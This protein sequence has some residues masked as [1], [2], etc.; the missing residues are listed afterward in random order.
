MPKLTDVSKDRVFEACRA[1][2]DAGARVT[3]A[4]VYEQLGRRGSA[5]VVQ[6]FIAIWQTTEDQDF[7]P[8]LPPAFVGVLRELGTEAFS[9]AMREAES[10]LEQRRTELEDQ[11]NAER[12]ATQTT[13]R[14][15]QDAMKEMEAVKCLAE[16]QIVVMRQELAVAAERISA[17]SQ[18]VSD[19]DQ[20]V[21]AVRT[22]L[23]GKTAELTTLAS[24]W[25]AAVAALQ[26]E[27]RQE[28]LAGQQALNQERERAAGERQHLM[29][30]T[31]QIRQDKER[32]IAELKGQLQMTDK[33]LD[34][35]RGHQAVAART[36]GELRTALALAIS[37]RDEVQ[38]R[39]LS[40]KQQ[41]DALSQE[42]AADRARLT[43][44]EDQI[45]DLAKRAVPAAAEKTPSARRRG[46]K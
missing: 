40:L 1:V 5:K 13:V 31:D 46:P 39:E 7:L 17:L 18:A 42:R 10:R 35:A 45:M 9:A 6:E 43:Q 22:E 26:D 33:R 37:T 28:R 41:I 24:E 3:F 38:V 14:G 30:Q 15:A 21:A 32:E 2:R 44:L 29:A 34:E 36:E 4:R 16:D 8:G 19:R 12:E 27:L 11:A 23:A 25:N 20:A